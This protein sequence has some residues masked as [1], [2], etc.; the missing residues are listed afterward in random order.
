MNFVNG[1]RDID[2]RLVKENH[3]IFDLYELLY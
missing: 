1:E 2:S 3:T